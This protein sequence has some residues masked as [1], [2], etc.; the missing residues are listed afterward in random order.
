[1]LHVAYNLNNSLAPRRHGSNFQNLIFKCILQN[2][3]LGTH[4][5]ITFRW[6]PQNLTIE[7][8]TLVQVMVW[9]CQAASHYLNQCW[10]RSVLSYGVTGPQ[11]VNPNC[12]G[13]GSFR[14]NK[15]NTVPWVLMPWLLASPDL[16]QPCCWL[17]ERCSY[18]LWE[19]IS[20][21]RKS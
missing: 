12:A 13:N 5:E 20:T 9:C 2:S 3:R 17:K 10:P 11:W 15:V 1:M 7:K 8:S 14:A 4:Y 18:L 16:Q 6:M 19:W 21:C